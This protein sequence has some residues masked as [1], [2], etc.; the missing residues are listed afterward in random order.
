MSTTLTPEQIDQIKARAAQG[1]GP[2]SISKDFNV[3][4]ALI[5]YHINREEIYARSLAR[6]NDPNYVSKRKP[7]KGKTVVQKGKQFSVEVSGVKVVVHMPDSISIGKVALT[8]ESI[9]LTIL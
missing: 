3:S 4:P 6:K 5:H 8:E 2:T 1:E 9:N 7:A